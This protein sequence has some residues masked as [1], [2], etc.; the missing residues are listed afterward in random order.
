MSKIKI[1]LV[2]LLANFLT[3]LFSENVR[4]SVAESNNKF[5]LDLYNELRQTDGNLFFSSYSIFSALAMTYE[6][7]NGSTAKEMEKSLYLEDQEKFQEKFQS[8][9]NEINK[10][11]KKYELNS[12]NAI[13]LQN[14]YPFK[15]DYIEKI[16]QFYHGK[17]TNLNFAEKAESSRRTINNWIEKKTNDKIKKLISPNVLSP[18]TRMVLTN[19]IYFKGKWKLEFKKE[20]TEKRAFHLNDQNTIQTNMMRKTDYFRY[21]ETENIQILE[22]EY[23]GDDLSMLIILPKRNDIENIEK[24]LNWEKLQSWNSLLKKEKVVVTIPKFTFETKYFLNDYLINMGIS[25]AF[26]SSADFSKM[27]PTA[28]LFISDVIHQAFLEVSEEGTEA[29]A[30]TAVVMEAL[31]A[32]PDHKPE[33]KIFNADHPFLFLIQQKE[34]KN[35][36]FFGRLKNPE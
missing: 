21:G 31:S 30:A 23:E 12:A 7:A 3:Q 10:S 18:L 35:I 6:G 22:M 9:Q 19:A 4:N 24:L 15:K 27:S 33:I 1:I 29:A 13:W 11:K 34:T 25:A 14:K 20:A 2:L 28:E 8:L 26:Q 17:V 16:E 36:L 5:C 32:G